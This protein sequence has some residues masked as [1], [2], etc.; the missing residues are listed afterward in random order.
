M[1]SAKLCS[2]SR[3]ALSSL[4]KMDDNYERGMRQGLYKVGKNLKETANKGILKSTKTGKYYKYKGRKYRASGSGEYPANVSGRNRRGI[5]FN[6]VGKRKLNFGGTEEHSKY[7]V[8]GTKYMQPRDFLL[9]AINQTRQKNIRT[10]AIEL[11]K[12]IKS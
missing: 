3:K 2:S 12:E 10:L 5:Q 6:V 7:L 8:E 1:F 11:N 4:D 9:K